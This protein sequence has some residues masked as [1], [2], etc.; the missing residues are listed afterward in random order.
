MDA[1]F[2]PEDEDDIVVRIK[3][4]MMRE[5]ARASM[6][7]AELRRQG[8]RRRIAFLMSVLVIS[9][10]GY[11]GYRYYPYLRINRSLQPSGKPSDGIIV[12]LEKP[13]PTDTHTLKKATVTVPNQGAFNVQVFDFYSSKFLKGKSVLS[14]PKPLKAALIEIGKETGNS[15]LIIFAGASFEGDPEENLNL[16]QQRIMA[17]EQ[18]LNQSRVTSKGCWGMRAGEM[19]GDF[20][21]ARASN[22]EE[23][24]EEAAKSIGE[25]GLSRQ[26]RLI[27]AQI[28]R[29]D[30]AQSE[31][32]HQTM[33]QLAT[34]F[35]DPNLLPNNYD[36]SGSAPTPCTSGAR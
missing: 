10:L 19:K 17:V 24:E 9:G 35:Y 8:K 11:L 1:A 13:T 6:R 30:Q 14:D 20:R 15:S 34:A 29:A 21:D 18:M 12:N 22:E 16:C 28:T 26:R 33:I 23:E 4:G 32:D 25:S 2:R 7:Q 36:F 31:I 5:Q 3:E 27:L